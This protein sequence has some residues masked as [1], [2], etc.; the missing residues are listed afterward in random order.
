L[1]NWEITKTATSVLFAAGSGKGVT[2]TYHKMAT[3]T[4]DMAYEWLEDD[5]PGQAL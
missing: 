1:G 2:V 5:V 3:D 4:D